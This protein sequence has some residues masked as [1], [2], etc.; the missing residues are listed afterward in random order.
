MYFQLQGTPEKKGTT[1]KVVQAAI[2]EGTATTELLQGEIARIEEREKRL[3]E[4]DRE[5]VQKTIHELFTKKIEETKSFK[6][7]EADQLAARLLIYEGLDY[8][9]RARVNAA[10][11]SG[12]KSGDTLQRLE[13]LSES[14]W[15]LLIRM[16]LL[17][18][19]ESKYSNSNLA[20]CL[21]QVAK[22]AGL[23]TEAIQKAQDAK[24]KERKEKQAAR[25]K[26]LKKRMGGLKKAA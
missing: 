13:G 16:A 23:D 12:S 18:K 21:A 6:L 9:A 15:A 17:S 10:L 14:E 19:P 8:S 26:D 22:A 5:K 7:T 2:K 20:P 11:F 25:I 4:I 3:R 24:A 1:A